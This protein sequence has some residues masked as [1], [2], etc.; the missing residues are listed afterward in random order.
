MRSRIYTGRVMHAR[1]SP[2]QHKFSY[3]VYFYRFD[4]DE[5]DH[6]DQEVVGFGHNRIRPVALHDRDYLTPGDETLREKL[7][8][9]VKRA[10][11]SL[12]IRKVTL[13]TSARVMHYVFN[14]VSFFFCYGEQG[15]LEAVVVQV[16]NTFGEMHIYLLTVRERLTIKPTR[17]FMCLLFLTAS[18]PT[19]FISG[20][21]TGTTLISSFST[22]R[23][24]RSSSPP[25]SRANQSL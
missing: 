4:L 6:L 10:G 20:T 14:P 24:K 21:L 12:D 17:F 5:I 15:D 25:G 13:V 3:P 2:V 16:N 7:E 1:S 18:A 11:C 22:G 19:I 23:G 9:I 8:A